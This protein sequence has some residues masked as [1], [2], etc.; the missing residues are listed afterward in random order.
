MEE[1]ER[2]GVECGLAKLCAL[3][4]ASFGFKEGEHGAWFGAKGFDFKGVENGAQVG[5]PQKE[6]Q[7]RLTGGSDEGCFD[8]VGQGGDGAAIVRGNGE[9]NAPAIE[10]K[11]ELRSV[12][13]VLSVKRSAVED[14]VVEM[15]PIWAEPCSCG[16]IAEIG[17]EGVE[18][19]YG[20][21]EPRRE[22]GLPFRRKWTHGGGYPSGA[23]SG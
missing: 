16:G 11:G 19:V 3:G 14:E 10:A 5:T 4:T 8:V 13:S 18:V 20:E 22:G 6:V 21:A 15:E 1:G 17:S 9:G 12:E 23:E 2:D 7:G